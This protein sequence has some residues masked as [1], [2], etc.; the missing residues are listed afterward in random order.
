MESLQVQNGRNE[1]YR[2]CIARA[3]AGLGFGQGGLLTA[4]RATDCTEGYWL[5]RGLLTAGRAPDCREGYWLQ[6]ELLT[7]GRAT[8]CRE[9]YWLQGGLL[10]AGRATDRDVKCS[11]S[12]KEKHYTSRE[13]NSFSSCQEIYDTLRIM[14]PQYCFPNNPS[15][16]P[17]PMKVNPLHDIPSHYWR[18]TP[19]F[20]I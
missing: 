19:K 15:L 4:G 2:E 20:H 10:T 3:L 16:V 17:I 6:G 5:H 11:S 18:S 8:A 7:A 13:S 1:S 14:K 12:S 9:G